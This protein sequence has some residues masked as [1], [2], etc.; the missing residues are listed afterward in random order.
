MPLPALVSLVGADPER[1]STDHGA[2]VVATGSQ[3]F[4][5]FSPKDSLRI[6]GT[7]PG[8]GVPRV[9]LEQRRYSVQ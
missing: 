6:R 2:S 4:R 5:P 3:R 8:R 9:L 1:H 7:V